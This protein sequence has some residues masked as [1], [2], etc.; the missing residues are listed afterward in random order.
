MR[1]GIVVVVVAISASLLVDI[2]PARAAENSRSVWVWGEPANLD[3]ETIAAEGFDRILLWAPPGFSNDSSFESVVSAVHV[4]G[5][6]IFAVGGDPSWA[7]SPST[8]RSWAREV[9]SGEWDGAVL[10]IE[11]YL[12]PDWDTD[13]S[14]LAAA[15]L[16]GLRRAEQTLSVPL[17]ATVPF[18][19]DSIPHRKT[20]VL[21]AVAKRVDGIVVLGYRDH[22]EGTDGI[23]ELVS[24]E[25]AVAEATRTDLV[26]AVETGPVLPEKVTFFEEGRTALETE[27][28]IVEAALGTSVAF[29]GTSVHHWDS[30]ITIPD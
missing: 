15:Y 23:L 2:S 3:I 25:V 6:E 8:V 30:L 9:Q 28:G 14:D 13:R 24:E 29:V 11:P 5:L 19:F 1:W 12:H 20:T 26:I 7:S 10:N 22:A 16:R 27:L 17:S 21:N 18:W 4:A